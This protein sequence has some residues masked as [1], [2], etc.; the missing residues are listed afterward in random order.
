MY[1]CSYNHYKVQQHVYA[2]FL[3]RKYDVRVSQMLLVQCHPALGEE[4]TDFNAVQIELHPELSSQVLLAF[5]AGW[6]KLLGNK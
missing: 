1:D 3:L 4:D 6:K 5:A 2:D